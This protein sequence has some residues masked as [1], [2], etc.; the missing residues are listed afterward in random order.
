MLH[1]FMTSIIVSEKVRGYVRVKSDLINHDVA[2]K[3]DVIPNFLFRGKP[4][5]NSCI[6]RASGS[7]N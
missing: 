5:Q 2:E 4:F 1:L 7:I 3:L 6:L